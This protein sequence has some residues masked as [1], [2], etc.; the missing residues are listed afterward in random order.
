MAVLALTGVHHAWGALVFDTP[1]RLEI[2]HVAIPSAL[3]IGG[4]LWLG[5]QAAQPGLAGFAVWIAT[6]LILIFPVAL[7][8]LLEGGYN[9]LVKNAVYFAFG[10]QRAWQL[11]PPQLY[12][13]GEVEM[14]SDIV[15]EL[16]GVAQFPLGV[17]AGVAAIKLLRAISRPLRP[18][19]TNPTKL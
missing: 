17:M 2:L 15:F 10:E 12:A 3:A 7:I 11:F 14:P 16:T 18:P 6:V 19:Q 8:G 9:H 1:W 4:A 5:R 13:E